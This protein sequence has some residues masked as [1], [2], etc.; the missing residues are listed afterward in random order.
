[1]LHPFQ[2][3]VTAAVDSDVTTSK[4]VALIIVNP[5]SGKKRGPKSGTGV[6]A[7]V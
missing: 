4:K 5:H 3:F 1:M 2:N 7:D 6:Q